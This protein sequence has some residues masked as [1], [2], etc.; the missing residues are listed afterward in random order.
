MQSEEF[1]SKVNIHIIQ[2]DARV[3]SDTKITSPDQLKDYLANFYVRGFGVRTSG[4]SSTTCLTCKT[5]ASSRTCRASLY[6]TDGLGYYP[7]K[8]PPYD[9][10]FVFID[11][12][13]THLPN[14]PPWAMRVV[15]D[16]D[17][18]NRF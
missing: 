5:E 14:V 1:G 10:A 3:Q 12:G 8:M 11:N 9:V 6:F 4:P 13:E 16:E 7:D 18:I 17:G 2:C 15:I